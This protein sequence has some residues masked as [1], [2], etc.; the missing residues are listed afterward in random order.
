MYFL[1]IVCPELE[2]ENKIIG[3]KEDIRVFCLLIL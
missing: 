1:I 2:T 3:L